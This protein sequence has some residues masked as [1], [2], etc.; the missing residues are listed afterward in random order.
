[1]TTQIKYI[2]AEKM[3]APN[4]FALGIAFPYLAVYCDANRQA[5]EG[6]KR[7]VEQGVQAKCPQCGFFQWSTQRTI[8]GNQ[9]VEYQ[10]L[11]F[12]G[13]VLTQIVDFP[14]PYVQESE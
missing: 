7:R 1:M 14:V 10:N 9:E 3:N 11:V 13:C 2:I 5:M 4:H 12:V 8:D 6:W